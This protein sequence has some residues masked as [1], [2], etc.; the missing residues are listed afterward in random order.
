MCLV[1]VAVKIVGTIADSDI[2]SLFYKRLS[3][4]MLPRCLVPSEK[5]P[6]P[7]QMMSLRTFLLQVRF[8]Y[9]W[10]LFGCMEVAKGTLFYLRADSQPRWSF[11]SDRKLF[12]G[13]PR[14]PRSHPTGFRFSLGIYHGIT[15]VLLPE[16]S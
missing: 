13:F 16:D 1:S 7:S 2:V 10:C 12:S 11:G 15:I 9:S 3:H 6:T 4:L 8:C 14:G 5:E